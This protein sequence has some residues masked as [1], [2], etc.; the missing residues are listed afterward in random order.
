MAT[1][2]LGKPFFIGGQEVVVVRDIV[3]TPTQATKDPEVYSMVEPRGADGRPP[4]YVSESNLTRMR[5][6]YPG[7]DVYGLWQILFHNK[8]VKFG[9]QV[10]T[11]PLNDTNGL[12]LVL[13]ED[14]G[15]EFSD[16]SRIQQSG[17]YIENF[18][19]DLFDYDLAKAAST[20]VDL[21]TLS[22]PDQ[23]AYTRAELS[24]K[25]K[26]ENNRRRMIVGALCGIISVA[27][28][29]TNYGLMTIHNSKMADY[30][31]KKASVNE[32]KLRA[33]GLATERMIERP[34]DSGTLTQLHKVF[35]IAPESWTP[36]GG[37]MRV[38]FTS[39]HVI[40]TKANFPVN[41]ESTKGVKATLQPDLSYRIDIDPLHGTDYEKAGVEEE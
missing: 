35:Q 20:N 39:E 24:D 19:V 4:I 9:A 13:D 3:G 36:A 14:A 11:F 8:A 30:K 23:P 15:P 28:V 40:I 32:L 10:L 25:I 2:S 38:G 29:A 16:P 12:Y 7:I 34:N 33:D 31:A 27:A 6:H 37:D 18:I 21:A 22:L 5:E 17:E 41:P 26:A 1:F